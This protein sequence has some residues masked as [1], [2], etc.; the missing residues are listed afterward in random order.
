M[1]IGVIR[2]EIYVPW[3][4][5]LKEKR[6]V[7]KSVCAKV[8]N[9]FNVSIA[10]TDEQDIHQRIVLGIALVAGEASLAD[11][12]MDHVLNF[13]EGS[14]EGEIINIEREFR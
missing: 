13:I 10:E 4:H 7:V 11:S 8:R 1:I 6:M 2:V 5:S 3:V 12:I 9:K 14:T